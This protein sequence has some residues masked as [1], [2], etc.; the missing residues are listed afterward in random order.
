[1]RETLGHSRVVQ[2][3]MDPLALFGS[4]AVITAEVERC[5]RAA[6]PQGHILNVGHGVVQGTPEENV[7]LFCDLA[8][9]SASVFK[10]VPEL[11]A[12]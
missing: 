8:R 6:G 2:G 10:K 5:L 11:T 4:E 7:G 3:N 1:M 9:S 12:V